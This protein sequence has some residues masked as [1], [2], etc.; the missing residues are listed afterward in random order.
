M[1]AR[2]PAKVRFTRAQYLCAGF[3]AAER[4]AD[5]FIDFGKAGCSNGKAAAWAKNTCEQAV[6][7]LSQVF[8]FFQLVVV[9][10]RT[11]TAP[12]DVVAILRLN[13]DPLVAGLGDEVG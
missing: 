11:T 2:Q 4:I 13:S 10:G 1:H 8:Q 5:N 3:A 12:L 6:A 7:T 9:S